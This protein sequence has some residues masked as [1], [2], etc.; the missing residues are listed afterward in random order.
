[1]KKTVR[2]KKMNVQPASGQKKSNHKLIFALTAL[3]IVVVAVALIFLN[4]TFGDAPAGQAVKTVKQTDTGKLSA[5]TYGLNVE[6]FSVAAAS[7]DN[8]QKFPGDIVTVPVF[9]KFAEKSDVDAIKLQLNYDPKV[10]APINTNVN[11]VIVNHI[12]DKFGTD[13]KSKIDTSKNHVLYSFG[14][15]VNDAVIFSDV[16]PIFSAKFVVVATEPKTDGVDKLEIAKAAWLE[17]VPKVVTKDQ[18]KDEL[19]VFKSVPKGTDDAQLMKAQPS[20]SDLALT[21]FPHCEDSDNDK[22]GKTGTDN[23]GCQYIGQSNLDCDDNDAKTYPGAKEQCNNKDN[24]CDGAKDSPLA[25]VVKGIP[26]VKGSKLVNECVNYEYCEDG[27]TK[28][29]EKAF[30]AGSGGGTP[31]GLLPPGNIWY[32]YKADNTLGTQ[33]ITSKDTGLVKMYKDVYSAIAAGLP[34][35]ASGKPPVNFKLEGK[36]V[37]LCQ[38]GVFFVNEDNGYWKYSYNGDRAEMKGYSHDG[39]V[40]KNGGSNAVCP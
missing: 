37:W 11:S 18:T 39:K 10:L 22:R 29:L 8:P 21:I 19:G 26:A 4:P 23:R 34:V 13:L 3:V 28:L 2:Q 14:A 9:V 25:G 32:S 12:K 1:M 35:S 16:K 15:S 27:K 6:K 7:K 20:P 24:N 17:P 36:E 31:A 40:L 38:N 5:G 33:T 30:C